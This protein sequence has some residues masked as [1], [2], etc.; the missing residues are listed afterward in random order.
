MTNTSLK[1]QTVCLK[2]R[3]KTVFKDVNLEF[4]Q[5]EIVSIIGPNGSGKS[6]IL[7]ALSRILTPASGYVYLQNESLQKMPT[8]CVART[9]SILPQS[10]NAPGDMTVR[11]LTAC[12][13]I[14]YQNLWGSRTLN[15]DAAIDEALDITGLTKLQNRLLNTLSGGE[16]QRAWLSMALAQKPKILLLD[17]PTTYLDVKHQLEL[18]ELIVRLHRECDM[19]IIMV[20]HDLN[21]AA[22][23]STRLIAVKEGIVVADGKVKEVFTVR[24]LEE[25]YDVQVVVTKIERDG[26]SYPICL[27]YTKG[28]Y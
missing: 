4:L 13:R 24:V 1:M 16:K 5:P 3:D 8:E 15:D 7:K 17:E 10:A 6:T 23:Y 27:P 21:H 22:R 11:D 20:L 26:C 18:M 2:Y 19:T 28:N 14:P 9:I 25:L 12:G